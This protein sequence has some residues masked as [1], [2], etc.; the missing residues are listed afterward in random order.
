MQRKRKNL[1]VWVAI[2]AL[3]SSCLAYDGLASSRVSP[4]GDG[5]TVAELA[6]KVPPPKLLAMVSDHGRER[7]VWVGEVPAMTVRSGPPYYVFDERGK[8][9][10]WCAEA[11]EGREADP[12]LTAAFAAPQISLKEALRWCEI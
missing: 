6:A 5:C 1:L 11:G 2:A 10:E 9:V 8:L 7:L 3:V 12:W 4:P